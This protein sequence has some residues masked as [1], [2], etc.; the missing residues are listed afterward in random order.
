[1]TRPLCTVRRI[2]GAM[3]KTEASYAQLLDV[4]QRLGEILEYHFEALTFK[5]AD[6]CRYCPDFFVVLADGTPEL[7][8]VKGFM[9]D[10][11]RVKARVCARMFPFRVK[12]VRR[13][14]GGTWEIEEVPA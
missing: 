9:R 14:K 3:N 12:I 1:M 13:S 10:D 4:R 7:H 5:L 11:A 2:P 6:D 8:E